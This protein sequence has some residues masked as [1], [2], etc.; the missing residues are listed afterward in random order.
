MYINPAGA[1]V[2]NCILDFA[3]I[4]V[5]SQKGL[6]LIPLMDSRTRFPGRP[7]T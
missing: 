7:G 6:H 1:L 4:P 2:T 3:A 5:M